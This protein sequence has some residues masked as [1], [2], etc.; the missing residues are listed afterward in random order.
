MQIDCLEKSHKEVNSAIKDL[1]AQG[2]E[3]IE[4]L[5]VNGQ[6]YI[7]A[8]V[9]S[10]VK[11]RILGTPGP[12][13]AS[14]ADGPEIEVFGNVEDHLA[15]TMNRGKVV[16]H[17]MGGDVLGLSMRGGEVFIKGDAGYR[18][19]IHMKEYEENSAKMVIGGKVGDFLGEYMAGGVLVVLGIGVDPK[20][21]PVGYYTGTGLHGGVIYIRGQVDPVQLG[22]EVTISELD[23]EDYQ[24]LTPLLDT[25]CERFSVNKR[26]ILKD[27]FVKIIPKSQ[28]P[29]GQ[30]YVG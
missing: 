17:G 2:E 20:D 8:G 16:V 27:P 29:Y 13:L 12:D 9:N 24:K 1:I 6:R 18:V 15:N 30:L 28:R 25:Y 23:E 21:S 10:N 11:I 26:Q 14:F 7:G 5:N 4:L 22:K 19:G 3:A